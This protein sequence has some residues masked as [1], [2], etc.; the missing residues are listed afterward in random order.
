MG[1]RR[2]LPR[3]ANAGRRRFRDVFDARR[4]REDPARRLFLETFYD[5]RRRVGTSEAKRPRKVP[6]RVPSRRFS[7]APL[8]LDL[9][10]L[11]GILEHF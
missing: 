9:R 11:R 7:S 10:F 1:R 6:R 3:R 4:I 2:F 8:G 5:D